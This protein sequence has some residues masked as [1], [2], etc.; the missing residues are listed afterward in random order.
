M[1]EELQL[2]HQPERPF[3]RLRKTHEAQVS[4]SPSAS[5]IRPKVENDEL[6]STRSPPQPQDNTRSPESRAEMQLPISPRTA[7]KNKGKQ[8]VMSRPLAP[9]VPHGV[10]FKERAVAEPGIVLIP[11]RNVNIHQLLKP[12]DEPFT[13]DMAQDEVPIAVILPGT[14]L[15]ALYH[16]IIDIP[17]LG[18]LEL[19]AKIICF[20][21]E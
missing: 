10:R 2:P 21:C 13:D 7:T 19:G 16:V 11:K 5:S 1:D 14:C 20:Y 9:V 3:K 6:L 18:S 8:P 12:K 17:R 4:Q 15:F